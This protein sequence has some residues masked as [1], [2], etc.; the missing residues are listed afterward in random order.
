[1]TA[2]MAA[3]AAAACGAV[4]GTVAADPTKRAQVQ[5]AFGQAAAQP[6]AASILA[7]NLAM[8][9]P[10]FRPNLALATPQSIQTQAAA[11][12]AMLRASAPPGSTGPP[13]ISAASAAGLSAAA[14]MRSQ[15]G[16]LMTAA[17]APTGAPPGAS[18][19]IAAAPMIRKMVTPVCT[20]AGTAGTTIVVPAGAAQNSQQ[21]KLY[22][23]EMMLEA[24]AVSQA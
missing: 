17:G 3:S 23:E 12:A 5:S 13:V 10:A 18:P 15:N 16:Q 20:V 7:P 11:A 21:H 19:Y 24:Q 1:M 6:T 9:H 14:A 22:N 8:M 2:A 4:T